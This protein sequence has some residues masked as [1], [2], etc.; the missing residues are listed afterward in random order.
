MANRFLVGGPP[1]LA[2]IFI[3]RNLWAQISTL[4]LPKHEV[5]P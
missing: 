4:R 5:A 2:G 3:I 1:T